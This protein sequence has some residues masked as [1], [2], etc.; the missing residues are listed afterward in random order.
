MS[1]GRI[2]PGGRSTTSR[3]RRGPDRL[4]ASQCSGWSGQVI[5]RSDDGGVTWKPET[6]SSPTTVSP[7]RTSGMTG[8]RIR[9]SSRG[10]GTWSRRWRIRIRSTPGWRTPGCSG[11]PTAAGP[12]RNCPRCAGMSPGR[13]GSRARAGCACTRSSWTRPRPAVFAAISAAG[14]FRSDDAGQT[15]RPV[16]HG[17]HSEDIP[18]PGAEVGHC[19]H[20]PAMHPSA[21]PCCTCKSTGT[22]C[23]VMTR[24]SRG[25]RSAATCRPTSGSRSTCTRTSR[26][27][28]TWSRSPATR[29]ISPRR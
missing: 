12:G 20:R 5:Q 22:S 21:R 16:N 11:R 10:S 27:P 18:D 6:T 15:W 1:A 25:T 23:A 14:A 3:G 2:S 8:R 17:L 9:G 28:S 4:Y 29:S 19:V 26:T 7:G 24:A 13:P